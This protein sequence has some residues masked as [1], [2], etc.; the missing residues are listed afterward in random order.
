MTDFNSLSPSSTSDPDET[1]TYSPPSNLTCTS[2]VSSSTYS[3][4]HVDAIR[5]DPAC[6]A[7]AI[8]WTCA[9]SDTS[10]FSSCGSLS[11]FDDES[12]GSLA[13]S[14]TITSHPHSDGAATQD[15]R[16]SAPSLSS[17]PA[18]SVVASISS[19]G[20]YTLVEETSSDDGSFSQL[21]ISEERRTGLSTVANKDAD[22][23]SDD[24]TITIGQL[25]YSQADSAQLPL[26][27]VPTSSP[28]G[29][30]AAEV[31]M[32]INEKLGRHATQEY[33]F[34]AEQPMNHE[35][36]SPEYH[37]KHL[38]RHRFRQRYLIEDPAETPWT[39]FHLRVSS[40]P[41]VVMTKH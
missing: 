39:V 9:R 22:E 33:S 1:H 31:K 15:D 11:I 5:I 6:H 29:S 40:P 30:I 23:W 8:P 3:E 34:E 2:S 41:P 4:N 37:L 36:H 14:Y 27:A 21:P 35:S 7:Y 19:S 24:D 20:S 16:C 17:S 10:P 26:I 28:R 18:A 38:G 13:D 32:H 12:S 25:D